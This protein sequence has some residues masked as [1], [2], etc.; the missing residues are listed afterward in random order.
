MCQKAAGNVF[1][2]LVG[3][4]HEHLTWTRGKPSEFNSSDVAARGFC[5]NCGT[6]LYYRSLG[7]PHVSMTIGSF[8]TP[9]LI[10]ILYEMGLEGR[11]PGLRPV[12]SAEQIGTTE[13]GDGV[14]A[15]ARVRASNHQHPDH[16]TTEW[17]PHH[18]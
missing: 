10:P 7:G 4:R 6:P 14:E 17:G 15:V 2:D 13:E 5:S 9:H 3:I 18:V 12:P 1:I 8:D 16:D 11:H